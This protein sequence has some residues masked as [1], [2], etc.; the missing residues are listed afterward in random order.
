[1]ENNMEV[2][3][4]E[5][6]KVNILNNLLEGGRSA[7]ELAATLKIRES[8]IR[9]HL[10]RMVEMGLLTSKFSREGVGR[11]KKKF[12]L[13]SAG[14]ELF[15]KRYDIVMDAMVSL[16]AEK[17]GDR[18][19]RELFVQMGRKMAEQMGEVVKHSEDNGGASS[20]PTAL[21]ELMNQMGEKA[22]LVRTPK[23]LTIVNHNC[24]YRSYA[25][26]YPNL[27]CEGYHRAFM[28]RLAAPYRVVCRESMARGGASCVFNVERL[29]KS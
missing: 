6:T 14:H 1:M 29:E 27:F 9:M 5:G 13:T 2:V 8:A 17:E 10:E 18:Y 4:G 24:I 19:V 16:L 21:V 25:M 12:T 26:K 11:P 23:G 22:E 15:T 3:L 7:R 20:K 28:E